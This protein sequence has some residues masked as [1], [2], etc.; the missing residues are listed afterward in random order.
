MKLF[1][2]KIFLTIKSQ[3]I[4]SQCLWIAFGKPGFVTEKMIAKMAP[5]NHQIFVPIDQNVTETCFDVKDPD[6]VFP[7]TRFV[8]KYPTVLMAVT[9]LDV[10]EM[11]SLIQKPLREFMEYCCAG[12]ICSNVMTVS[13]FRS[14][15]TICNI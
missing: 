10:S 11:I 8:T 5:T 7:T 13:S 14:R 4:F 2:L 1:V 15:Y 3:I 6:S 9:N 12:L